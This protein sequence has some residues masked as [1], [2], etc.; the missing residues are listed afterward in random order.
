MRNSILVTGGAGFVGT[1]FILNWVH[2]VGSP[3][4]NLDLLTYAWNAANLAALQTKDQYLLIHGDIC[5]SSLVESLLRSHEPKVVVNF[6]AESH[7]DRSILGPEAFVRTNVQGTFNLLE[8][9]RRYW[10]ALSQADQR[11]FRFIHVSTDEV[12]GSLEPKE[13]AF[14][15]LTAYAPNSPYAASKAASDH[16]VRAYYHTWGLP[17]ITTHCSNNYG[18]F[19][20]PEKLLPLMI[21]NAL[22]WKPLPVYGDGMNVRDWLYV[23]DHCSA[24]R[25]VLES[26]RV[27]QTYNIGGNSERTN[28]SVVKQI[29]DCL[30]EVCPDPNRGRRRNLIQ[31]V[32][33]RPGHDRRYAVNANK[34]TSEL[35]WAPS[36]QFESGLRKT[37]QWY[38]DNRDWTESIRSGTYQ[39][40]IRNNYEE[41]VLL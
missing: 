31:F 36:E 17:A 37:V 8:Q 13:P 34:I 19:Q 22:E 25:A 20:F 5:D 35:N 1:N 9:T 32:T 27:G 7:V 21:L 40:W 41:R 29:C 15:E 2:L 10:S 26:G 4:V 6:A 28:F 16:F 30:D 39:E 14:T 18:P 11:N 3:V 33:D 24:I 23:E 12:Y 38:L